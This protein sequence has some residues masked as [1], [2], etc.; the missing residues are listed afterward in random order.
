MGGS[1]DGIVE[2]LATHSIKARTIKGVVEIV[3][4]PAVSE[5][6]PSV[7]SRAGQDTI[8]FAAYHATEVVRWKKF[9]SEIGMSK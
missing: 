1:I 9:A 8:T 2:A 7:S 3:K 4:Q 5:S 6:A